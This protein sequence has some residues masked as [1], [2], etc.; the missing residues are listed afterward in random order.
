[1]T[2]AGAVVKRIQQEQRLDYEGAS[3][4]AFHEDM[5][6]TKGPGRMLGVLL[7]QDKQ[8]NYHVLK[9][10]SGQIGDTWFIKGWV[11]PL[12]TLTS[13]TSFYQEF[14]KVTEALSDKLQKFQMI[15]TYHQPKVAGKLRP[16][17]QKRMS[18]ARASSAHGAAS[19]ANCSNSSKF[20]Q[21]QMQ[22]LKH[23]RKAVS[24]HLMQLIQQSYVTKDCSG[25]P[26]SLLDTYLQYHE[27]VD[28]AGT[29]IT[30]AG[31]FRGFPAGT[32][33]CCCPKLLHAAAEQGL[34]PLSMVEFWYGSAPG[35]ATKAKA[36]RVIPE[37]GLSLESSRQHLQC[38]DMCEKCKAILGTMLCGLE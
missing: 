36:G 23:R 7:A 28:P 35:T 17:L 4:P 3:D 31:A 9:A 18:S 2:A 25:S 38:Y 19:G 15:Q 24:H 33:D 12:H 29:S 1:L 11:G 13:A 20:V 8:G 10:F 30:K 32:G 5:L 34:T 16:Q 26:V 27:T 22:L 6:F 14:R 37:G 21:D